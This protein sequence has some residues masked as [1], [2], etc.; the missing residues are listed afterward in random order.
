MLTI[1][2][3]PLVLPVG[4]AAVADGAVVV[5]GDRIA[6]I[7]PY[8]EVAAAYPAARV[9]RWP[10]L[11]TP[12]LR[13]DRARALLTRCYH[14]DPREADELGELPLW[15]EEFERI[16]A[17]MDTA[18]RAGSVRRGLQRMLRHGTTHVVGPFGAEEPALRTALARSGLTAVPAPGR[19]PN[20]SAPGDDQVP[21]GP[22]GDLDPF[23]YGGALGPFA[24]GGD[25][26]ATAHGPLTV[27]GRADL[28]VFDVPDEEA[29][30]T[31]GAGRCVATV[32]AGRLVHRAR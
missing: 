4:A 31:G 27:G 19:A 11:L 25:L 28:A 12:G 17:T 14:P 22:G 9:R 3:A 29:L 1:H 32:L 16:V 13:Q 26:A 10:G 2:A 23:A 18:R 6:A 21:S 7:G 30:R 15:G 8:E 5:D 24:Y 20:L